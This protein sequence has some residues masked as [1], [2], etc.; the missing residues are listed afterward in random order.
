M[1]STTT[2]VENLTAQDKDL[3][4]QLLSFQPGYPINTDTSWL[5]DQAHLLST[6]PP[7]LLK[8]RSLLPCL[9]SM[10]HSTPPKAKLCSTHSRLNAH[11]IHKIFLGIS[12]ECTTHLE[13]FLEFLENDHQVLLEQKALRDL[14]RKQHPFV[15]RMEAANGLWMTPKF[16]CS[17]FMPWHATPSD[18]RF[19]RI[20]SGCEACILASV[21]GNHVVL[22]DL[23]ASIRGRKKRGHPHGA[24]LEMVEAWID[25]T[26]RG[27]EIREE[28]S[29]QGK[30]IAK[31][32]REMQKVRREKRRGVDDRAMN[33]EK[34]E[35]DWSETLVGEKSGSKEV[36]VEFNGE[37]HGHDFEGGIIDFYVKML[38]T[39]SPVNG[40]RTTEG[41]H[42]AFRESIV[43][44][45]M[46]KKFYRVGRDGQGLKDTRPYSQSVYSTKS[47]ESYALSY[48]ILLETPE[49]NETE[50]PRDLQVNERSFI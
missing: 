28:S 8:P 42:E 22:S 17:L 21:G 32:R 50:G 15:R 18:F 12:A 6:F 14:V 24:V 37:S 39:A 1:T 11:L 4:A 26:G 47:S 3:L 25:W 49:A 38:S 29:K 44:D 23:R 5:H 46:G 35:K 7:H 43:H 19:E 20:E 16:Y 10:T 27:D 9:R 41:L 30:E 45:P 48:Q 40:V 36:D 34:E 2:K 31:C 33:F 13:R